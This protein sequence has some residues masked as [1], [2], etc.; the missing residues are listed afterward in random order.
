[1]NNPMDVS[2]SVNIW[3]KRLHGFLGAVLAQIAIY[4]LVFFFSQIFEADWAAVL[5]QALNAALV[6]MSVVLFR[7]TRFREYAIGVFILWA[8]MLFGWLAVLGTVLLTGDLM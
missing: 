5:Q 1:M 6:I 3:R 4:I 8:L 2:L 7:N